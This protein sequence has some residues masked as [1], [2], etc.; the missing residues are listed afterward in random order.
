MG[1]M[2]STGKDTGEL[3]IALRWRQSPA[4]AA[5]P[6]RSLSCTSLLT[7]ALVARVTRHFVH[8]K[9]SRTA[10]QA[11]RRLPGSHS[12]DPPS[13]PRC[14][15]VYVA[16]VPEHAGEFD[17]IHNQADFV[18]LPLAVGADAGGDNNP[19]L[20]R[21]ASCPLSGRTTIASIASRS[22]TPIATGSALCGDDPLR[23]SAEDFPST[24]KWQR[25]LALRPHPPDKGR[26]R[27]LVA[28]RRAVAGWP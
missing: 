5:T 22:A 3:R 10:W 14:G 25:R 1:L 21:H 23:Y 17:L 7:E 6:L 9:D 19:R 8:M 2:S 13:T 20:L 12:E 24:R 18:P 28:A 4:H 16:H 11:G 27:R 15:D 26:R